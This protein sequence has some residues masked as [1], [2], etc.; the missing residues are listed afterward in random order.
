[1]A[2]ANFVLYF[3]VKSLASPGAKYSFAADTQKFLLLSCSYTDFEKH[4]ILCKHLYLVHRIYRHFAINYVRPVTDEKDKVHEEDAAEFGLQ[5]E[6]IISPRLALQLQQRAQEELAKV[7]E[8]EI[9]KRAREV[10]IAEEFEECEKELKTAATRDV[11]G[12]R[13]RYRTQMQ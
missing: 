13:S 1:M 2:G 11:K 9:K 6:D 7:Q 4:R 8:E 10:A 3:E 12:V 5:L